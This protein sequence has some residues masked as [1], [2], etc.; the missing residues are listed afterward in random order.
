MYLPTCICKHASATAQQ[1]ANH[2]RNIGKETAVSAI[3]DFSAISSETG[4]NVL[5]ASCL[6]GVGG[7]SWQ[8][9]AGAGTVRR[10]LEKV[11]RRI[12]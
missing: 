1:R 2:V 11:S 3:S 12:T 9:E 10:S 8:P 4:G 5:L 6:V 7:R